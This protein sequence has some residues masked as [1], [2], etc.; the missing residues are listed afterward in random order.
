MWPGVSE[1]VFWPVDDPTACEGAEDEKLRKF[2]EVRDQI[3]EL[4]RA[5]LREKAAPQFPDQQRSQP[6]PVP[7]ASAARALVF[8]GRAQEKSATEFNHV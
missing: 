3:E 7:D 8:A 1:R 6:R 4:V 5:W 2:R